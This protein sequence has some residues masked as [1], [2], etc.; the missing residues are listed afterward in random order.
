MSDQSKTVEIV[1]LGNRLKQKIMQR[2]DDKAG[3]LDPDAVQKAEK[4]IEDL[5]HD[6]EQTINDL[7]AQIQEHSHQLI[8]D[9][10]ST[11][12]KRESV[13]NVFLLAHEIK[14]IAGMCKF[15]LTSYFAESLR[16]YVEGS[17]MNVKEQLIIMQAHIDAM[18]AC[19]KMGL[20]EKGTP[21]AQELKAMVKKAI[22]QHG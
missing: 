5:C 10:V 11:D 9:Q 1:D 13:L 22:E 14:D 19:Q 17:E 16:D 2:P 12:E 15:H 6:G 21:E 7:L 8:N 18:I 20:R 4:L 3:Y